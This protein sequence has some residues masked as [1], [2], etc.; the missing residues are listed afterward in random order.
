MKGP[1]QRQSAPYPEAD[2][3]LRVSSVLQEEDGTRA[4]KLMTSASRPQGKDRKKKK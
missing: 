1:I 2:L 4:A 3:Y